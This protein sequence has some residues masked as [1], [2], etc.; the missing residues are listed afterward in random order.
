[1]DGIDDFLAASEAAGV[2]DNQTVVCGEVN[3]VGEC[4][5]KR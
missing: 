2:N 4:L 3:R 5:D 1:M